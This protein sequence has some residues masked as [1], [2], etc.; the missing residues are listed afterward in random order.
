MS[1]CAKNVVKWISI[2]SHSIETF[3]R[4]NTILSNSVEIIEERITILSHSVE[5]FKRWIKIS[6]F[7]AKNVVRWPTL[8]F[9]SV[10]N[11]ERWFTIFSQCWKTCEVYNVFVPLWGTFC[12]EI[13]SFV[14]QC[15]KFW[16]L[17][18]GF[19]SQSWNFESWITILSHSVE[20]I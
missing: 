5:K 13:N 12:G 6:H 10:E 20:K 19:L 15:R 11:F 1:Y 16:E 9:H 18:Y 7:F 4:W 8:L 17:L 14:S 2:L 3:V